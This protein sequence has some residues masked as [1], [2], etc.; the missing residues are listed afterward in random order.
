MDWFLIALIGPVLYAISNHIDKYL[1]TKYFKGGEVGAVTLF[2]ALFGTFALPII[3][4]VEPDVFSIGLVPI[5]ALTLSGISGVICLILYFKAL[6]K[7]EASVVVPFYQTIPI[8][9]FIM[10][11]LILGETVDLV[12]VIDCSLIIAGTVVLSLDMRKHRTLFK[13]KVAI[14][15]LSASLIFALSGVIFKLIALEDGFWPSIF[16]NFVGYVLAGVILYAFVT[17]Y[18]R[19]FLKVI[20]SNNWKVLALNSLNE[21]LFIM[22]DGTAVYATLL[23]PIALVMTINGLQPLFVF[24]FGVLI[25]IFLPGL[26]KETMTKN[27]LAQRIL[28]IGLITVGTMALGLTGAL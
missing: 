12:Q 10:G 3:Y 21:T 13:K 22:A 24:L 28:A 25:T 27:S 4:S 14:L 8:F 20:K 7:E 17:P 1:L 9:G 2:S 16:W 5:L 23:A 18:R 15:M 6:Q 19:Q 11:F 26:P